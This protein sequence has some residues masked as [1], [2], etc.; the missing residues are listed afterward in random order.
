MKILFAI[1]I[2]L[3]LVIAGIYCNTLFR[4]RMII[5]RKV[6]EWLDIPSDAKVAVLGLDYAGLF[7]DV[8]KELKAPGEV[9]GVNVGD[10]R[11]LEQEKERIKENKVADRAKLVD[12][13]LLNLPLENREFDYVL[14]SFTFHRASP[15][16][17]KGRAIQEAVRIMKPNGTLVI[18]DFG[19][20]QEYRQ[21]LTN[22]GFN[23]IHISSTGFNG[24]WGGPWLPTNILVARRN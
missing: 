8:A 21:I 18:V 24:W 19:N 14:S 3:C 9:T 12:G 15:A 11:V 23:S 17:N 20:V 22:L 5:W 13:D 10:S 4:G 16:I 6:L 7:I 1:I 2:I